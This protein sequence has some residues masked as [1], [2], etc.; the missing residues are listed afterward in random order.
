MTPETIIEIRNLSFSFNGSA[1]LRDVNLQINRG[2]FLAL[3]GPNGGGKTT[4][5]RLML[6]LLEAQR[7]TIRILGRLPREAA[8]RIGYVP[9][10][11]HVNQHFPI[12]VLDVVLTGRLRTGRG[13]ARHSAADHA[14]AQKTLEKLGMW[15][16]RDRRIGDLSG[17]QRQRAFI[18]RALVTEPEI[19]FLDEPTSSVDTQGQS[20]LYHLLKELNERVTI[21]IV[22]HDLMV[23]SSYV[24]S[25]ACVNRQ[26]LY[27]DAAEV[28]AEML[29]MA[30]HCPVELVAHGL[31][32]RVFC[33]HGKE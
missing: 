13:W 3:I 29:D 23:L 15:D 25:V 33:D 8:H 27:H 9:Q 20:D 11:I 5:L 12:S 31:P 2:D 7:G 30:Y 18:A 26:L 10:Y 28:T 16:Y 4:L 6:G 14:T 32:H 1:V 21:L 19:L 24:K 17:G 22:S